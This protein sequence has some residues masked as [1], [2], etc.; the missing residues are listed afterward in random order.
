LKNPGVTLTGSTVVKI[1]KERGLEA[2]PSKGGGSW[3]GYIKGY[4]STL[5]ATDFFSAPG[6]MVLPAARPS[7]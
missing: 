1:L 5:W 4:G 2:G 3:D 7:P 6:S